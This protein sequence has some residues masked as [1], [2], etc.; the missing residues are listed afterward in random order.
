MPETGLNVLEGDT[1]RPLPGTSAFGRE[2]YPVVLRYDARQL[3]IGTR[4]NGLFLYD[5]AT[6]TPFLTEIDERLKGRRS[7]GAYRCPMGRSR[8]RR[9]LV[10]WGSSTGRAGGWRLFDQERG[11]P[12]NAIYYLMVDREGALWTAGRAR[13]APH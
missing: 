1:F 5:G 11:L 6:M 12:A 7:T 2:V 4:L 13:H 8:L 10:A 3:L 9:P